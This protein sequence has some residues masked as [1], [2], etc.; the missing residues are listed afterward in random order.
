MIKFFQNKH[1][2]RFGVSVIVPL[3]LFWKYWR[4]FDGQYTGTDMFWGVAVTV[5]LAFALYL[6]LPIFKKA[7]RGSIIWFLVQFTFICLFILGLVLM[8]IGTH[9]VLVIPVEE[10]A[11]GEYISFFAWL[12][13]IIHIVAKRPDRAQ[14]EPREMTPREIL[15]FRGPAAWNK[16]DR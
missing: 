1:F 12:M 2:K 7:E 10:E 4:T 8:G 11:W 3:L 16:A 5:T 6:Y 15:L 13:F 14:D 9:W